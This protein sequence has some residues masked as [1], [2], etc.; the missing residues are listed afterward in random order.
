M[1]NEPVRRWIIEGAVILATIFGPLQWAKTSASDCSPKFG[2]SET[3]DI[4]AMTSAV[5]AAY[6]ANGKP[7]FRSTEIVN[8]YIQLGSCIDAV[9]NALS[10][11]DTVYEAKYDNNLDAYLASHFFFHGLTNRLTGF[12]SEIRIR[13]DV[14]DGHVTWMRSS[15]FYHAL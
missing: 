15:V 8:D 1:I 11:A 14:R 9:L 10:A 3:I 7:R 5:K 12:R 13:L 2:A 6:S 4:E